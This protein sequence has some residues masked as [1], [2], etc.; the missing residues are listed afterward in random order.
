[1]THPI[2]LA[3]RFQATVSGHCCMF[4]PHYHQLKTCYTHSW[5]HISQCI[6]LLGPN[7]QSYDTI[8]RPNLTYINVYKQDNG[9]YGI[10]RLL[11][12]SL[13]YHNTYLISQILDLLDI[14][15]YCALQALWSIYQPRQDSHT[16]RESVESHCGLKTSLKITS[17]LHSIFDGLVS[18]M[19][20]VT[21]IYTHRVSMGR[22][23]RQR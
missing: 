1:M 7:L 12:R 4:V 6:R 16:G 17:T 10:Q 21:W 14:H 5:D 19:V 3:S 23:C 8:G 9:L 18:Y 15:T 13:L 22:E 20:A 11:G 2:K